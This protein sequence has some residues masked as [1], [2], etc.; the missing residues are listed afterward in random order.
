MLSNPCPTAVYGI[1]GDVHGFISILCIGITK[2]NRSNDL[3]F[4][5]Q[6]TGKYT[7]YLT[8]MHCDKAWYR[9]YILFSRQ[10]KYFIAA[11]MSP[12]CVNIMHYWCT[13]NHHVQTLTEYDRCIKKQNLACLSK[14]ILTPGWGLCHVLFKPLLTPADH[15]EAGIPY[16]C[17][18]YNALCIVTRTIRYRSCPVRYVTDRSCITGYTSIPYYTQPSTRNVNTLQPHSTC[19]GSPSVWGIM[20]VPPISAPLHKC[21]SGL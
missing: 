20:A 13:A 6:S 18:L 3:F 5:N 7:C 19:R 11:I 16:W 9:I 2:S 10:L 1:Y 21:P 8:V 12:K 14:V 15:W 4:P 17:F